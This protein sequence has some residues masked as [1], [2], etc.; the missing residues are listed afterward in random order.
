MLQVGTDEAGYGPLLGPLVVAAAVFEG[1]GPRARMRLPGAGDSKRIYA[2]GG[3]DALARILGPYLP[4]AGAAA[5]ARLG[6]L[7]RAASVRG[8]PR[9]GYAWYG[10]VE[11]PAFRSC[12]SPPG[13]RRLLL[14]PVCEREFNEGC[15][16]RGGKGNLLFAETMRLVRDALALSPAADA[17]IVCDKLGGRNRY[18][19]MLLSELG[20][21][22][23]VPEIEGRASS[24]YRL[25]VGGRGV[26]IRFEAKADAL[27]PLAGLASI[28]AK[29]L[30]ELFMQALNSYFGRRIAGLRPTAGYVQDGRRFVKEVAALLP[31][32]EGGGRGFERL[33]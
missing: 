30:R 32:V 1:E 31:E 26:R 29:Y 4:H 5:T 23:I 21:T 14:N 10:E 13:F 3:R 2:S 27:D 7:L 12:E 20:P 15:R 16:E 8:D 11:D 28:G 25:T 18:A 17:E 6:S 33:F 19:T 24:R 22:T 9:P